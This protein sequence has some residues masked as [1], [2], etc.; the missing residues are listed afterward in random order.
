MCSTSPSSSS[1]SFARP[2]GST[3]HSW[4]RFSVSSSTRTP[5]SIG[6]APKNFT[7]LLS[8]RL[9]RA[10]ESRD[11]ERQA[12]QRAA[13][14]ITAEQLRKDGLK[15]LAKDREDKEKALDKDRADRKL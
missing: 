8:L 6:W 2:K 7:T 5:R 4:P 1:N 13:D 9:E 15:G 10:R 12:L 3:T 14:G 11:R